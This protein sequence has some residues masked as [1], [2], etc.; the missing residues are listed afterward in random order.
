MPI[1]IIIRMVYTMD[2][3]QRLECLTQCLRHSLIIVGL[4][5]T[6]VVFCETFDGHVAPQFAPVCFS[7]SAVTADRRVA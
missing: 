5:Q 1:N 6:F 7:V 2:I 3:E 4:L